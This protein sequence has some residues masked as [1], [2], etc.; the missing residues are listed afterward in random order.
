VHGITG[1][2]NPAWPL[3]QGTL[4]QSLAP[5]L[6]AGGEPEWPGQQKLEQPR[7]ASPMIASRLA[8][9]QWR[10]MVEAAG[11]DRSQSVTR[12]LELGS[13]GPGHRGR[14]GV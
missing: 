9:R 14:R 11:S 6:D 10:R 5:G 1:W 8:R 3:L 7:R 13:E 2:G 4:S 12:S